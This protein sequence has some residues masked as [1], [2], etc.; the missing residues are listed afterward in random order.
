[1][2]RP[3]AASN[4]EAVDGQILLAHE[5]LPDIVSGSRDRC[6]PEGA[7]QRFIAGKGSLGLTAGFWNGENNLSFYMETAR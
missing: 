1:M 3:L 4:T 2:S 6:L 7:R 5:P